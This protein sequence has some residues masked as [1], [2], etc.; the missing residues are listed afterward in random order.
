MRWPETPGG[1]ALLGLAIAVGAL[2][3]GALLFG[4]MLAIT[5]ASVVLTSSM[6]ERRARQWARAKGFD[7]VSV[8]PLQENAANWP[9][10]GPWGISARVNVRCS[11]IMRT[12]ILTWTYYFPMESDMD[13]RRVEWLDHVADQS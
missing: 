3:Y 10:H 6:A 9:W 11:G 2:L 8:V 13:L 4:G 12:A 1:F 7:L 5:R